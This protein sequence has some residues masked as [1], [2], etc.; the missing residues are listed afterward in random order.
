MKG[1]EYNKLMLV[2]FET[3]ANFLLQQ[4]V[5]YDK[6]VYAPGL[7]GVRFCRCR[8]YGTSIRKETIILNNPSMWRVNRMSYQELICTEKHKCVRVGD[9]RKHDTIYI[10]AAAQA[11]A[12]L[13]T[14]LCDDIAKACLRELLFNDRLPK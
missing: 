4:P 10:G 6:L 12:Q 5:Y 9:K 7:K 11:S 8:L 3:S 14:E 13:E 1:S 2:V